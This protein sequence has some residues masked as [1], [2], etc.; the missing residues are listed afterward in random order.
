MYYPKHTIEVFG[1]F[2]HVGGW[3]ECGISISNSV[4][5]ENHTSWRSA[6]QSDRVYD[7]LKA[8]GLKV[9]GWG[10][11]AVNAVNDFEKF[12]KAMREARREGIKLRITL[13]QNV[14]VRNNE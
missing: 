14:A 2:V 9:G 7:L 6:K 13:D 5:H 11:S 1:K 8:N 12:K 3:D 10:G 4:F